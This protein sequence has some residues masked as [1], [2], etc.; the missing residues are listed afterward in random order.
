LYAASF[1]FL[2]VYVSLCVYQVIVVSV[3]LFEASQNN[4]LGT[5]SSPKYSA[6]LER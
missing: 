5:V 3:N 1:K 6:N 2:C 4:F